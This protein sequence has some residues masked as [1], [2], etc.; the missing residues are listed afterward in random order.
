M[1]REHDMS[2]KPAASGQS[3]DEVIATEALKNS[4]EKIDY[5]QKVSK[6]ESLIS[7]YNLTIRDKQT[8]T[9]DASLNDRTIDALNKLFSTHLGNKNNQ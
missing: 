2:N 1:N 3:N 7:K 9:S 5:Q 6:S 4:V 8:L